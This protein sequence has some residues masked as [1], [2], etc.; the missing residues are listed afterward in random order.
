M[1]DTHSP[2][3]LAAEAMFRRVY[4]PEESKMSATAEYRATQEAVRLRMAA[5]RAARLASSAISSDMTFLQ[6][7]IARHNARRCLSDWP[8]GPVL[9]REGMAHQLTVLRG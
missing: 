8:A 4:V 9:D 1:T 6:L 5:Q 7:R 3:R 2:A